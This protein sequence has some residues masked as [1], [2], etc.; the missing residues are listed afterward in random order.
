MEAAYTFANP[1]D[2]VMFFYFVSTGRKVIDR[3]PILGPKNI[4]YLLFARSLWPLQTLYKASAIY[5]ILSS[6]ITSP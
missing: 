3:Q 2:I 6:Y 5:S 4:V 1:S